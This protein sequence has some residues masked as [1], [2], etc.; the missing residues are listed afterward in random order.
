M[1]KLFIIFI[2]STLFFACNNNKVS[3]N[4]T[5]IID[6]IALDTIITK[7]FEIRNG[8]GYDIIIN[9][10]LVNRQIDS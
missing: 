4:N 5:E 9:R 7:V 3:D 1:K 8:W 10:Q 6:S 2:S